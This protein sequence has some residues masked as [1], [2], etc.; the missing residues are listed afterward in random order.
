MSSILT[1][2]CCILEKLFFLSKL[3][4][5]DA[6]KLSAVKIIGKVINDYLQL[7]SNVI[8]GYSSIITFC[9]KILCKF[10]SDVDTNK[11]HDTNR[12]H[13]NSIVP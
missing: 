5:D 4:I 6:L 2:C 9:L 13:E 8:S 10:C 1:F 3:N 11:I 7:K 12:Y